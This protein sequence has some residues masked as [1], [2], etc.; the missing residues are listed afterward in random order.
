MISARDRDAV[1]PSLTSPSLGVSEQ[2]LTNSLAVE[3]RIRHQR[4]DVAHRQRAVETGE[5][6]K[7]DESNYAVI[8][9]RDT[10]CVVVRLERIQSWPNFLGK[11]RVAEL[12]KK[13]GYAL[14]VVA[15]G[16]SY[17][18]GCH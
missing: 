18:R 1:T 6:M 5:P 3:A 16:V 4:G 2:Q 7:P 12:A 15:S 8:T 11:C 17:L 14:G 13:R 10:N 9:H